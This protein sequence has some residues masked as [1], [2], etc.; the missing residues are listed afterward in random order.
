[1]NKEL[2]SFSYKQSGG[3]AGISKVYETE[4]SAL[5]QADREKL[6][7][8]IKLSGILKVKT[9]SK[10]TPRAADMFQY[11]F[12]VVDD[13]THQATY[14]DGALP[15]DFRYLFYFARAPAINAKR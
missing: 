10:K 2:K 4:F 1:M 7:G 15:A 11:D 5:D 6:E 13:S 3:F 9:V 8:A 12:T 14:D